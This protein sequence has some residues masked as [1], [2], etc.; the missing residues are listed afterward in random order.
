MEINTS[1][2]SVV[3]QG[4]VYPITPFAIASVRL[5]LP[6]SQIIL[7]TWEGSDL[8]KIEKNIKVIL[9]RDPHKKGMKYPNNSNRMILST[10]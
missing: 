4:A 6:D 2:I 9:N 10:I 7:S 5:L 3:M 8:S 1:E